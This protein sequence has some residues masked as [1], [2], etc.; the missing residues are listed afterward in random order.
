MYWGS[1]RFKLQS[2]QF[3]RGDVLQKTAEHYALIAGEMPYREYR[4][5][6]AVMRFL[7]LDPPDI[8]RRRWQPSAVATVCLEAVLPILLVVT[9]TTAVAVGLGIA[10]HLAFMALFPKRLLP[11]SLAAVV[12]YLAFIDLQVVVGWI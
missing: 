8:V 4:Y 6:R 10:M 11:F 2:P 9:A 1:V 3:M 5:P 12:S 7:A